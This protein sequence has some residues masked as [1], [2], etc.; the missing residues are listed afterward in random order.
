M[1]V[2]DFLKK[3]KETLTQGHFDVRDILS[4]GIR[5][6]W[7]EVSQSVSGRISQRGQVISQQWHSFFGDN[8]KDN[9]VTK[10][11][12]AYSA[13]SPADELMQRLQ[14]DLG[15]E[16][17][18]GEWLTIDQQRVNQFAGVT[19]DDQWIHT[20]PERSVVESPFK[21]T[22]AHGF[23]TMS[24]VPYL[25]CSVNEQAT[26]YPDAKMVVNYGLDNVRFLFPVKV[27][28]RIRARSKL[29]RVEAIRHGL[30]VVREVTIDIEGV[31]RPASIMETIARVYY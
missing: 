19:M 9:R 2:I 24:L 28:C 17:F 23:L 27:G 3:K 7:S 30:E 6:Y 26:E 16:T 21:S 1:D 20:N 29:I 18:V 10:P 11:V 5:D 12:L 31:R 13:P 8:Q 25:T 14:A 4:P 15:V 22:I